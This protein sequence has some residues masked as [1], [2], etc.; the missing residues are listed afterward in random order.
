MSPFLIIEFLGIV[1]LALQQVMGICAYGY[2]DAFVG[3]L[4]YLG[5][6][7]RSAAFQ[8]FRAGYTNDGPRGGARP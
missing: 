2:F 7:R 3:G 1:L 4:S 5:Y 8:E 6:W